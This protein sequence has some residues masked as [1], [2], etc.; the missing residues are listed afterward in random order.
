MNALKNA[1][2]SIGATL[3]E[4]PL[5]K[6][7]RQ[8]QE[9]QEKF[10]MATK[11]YLR[12]QHTE[13]FAH[14]SELGSLSTLASLREIAIKFPQPTA[15][16]RIDLE[17]HS[18]IK[19]LGS[20]LRAAQEVASLKVPNIALLNSVQLNALANAGVLSTFAAIP[21]TTLERIRTLTE[22]QSKLSALSREIERAGTINSSAFEIVK[23]IPSNSNYSK[24]AT[25][26]RILGN[27]AFKLTTTALIDHKW[28]A[29]EDFSSIHGQV[30]EIAEAATSEDEDD[31]TVAEIRSLIESIQRFLTRHYKVITPVA[32][33]AFNILMHLADIHQYIGFLTEKREEAASKNELNELKNEFLQLKNKLDESAPHKVVGHTCKVYSKPK[34][35]SIALTKIRRGAEVILLDTH[36][37]WAYVSFFDA[38][39]KFQQTGWVLK[40]YLCEK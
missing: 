32:I 22:N 13:K 20:A 2:L 38:Q 34:F 5:M 33:V 15:I 3:P 10:Q 39:D 8:Q 19:T 31:E 6:M 28:E 25:L 27:Q 35:R 4:S 26:S 30:V 16:K 1:A 24:L 36:G 12:F 40:K 14:I 29:I 7:L 11:A 9:I 37:K 18:Q 21:P 23:G 17:L